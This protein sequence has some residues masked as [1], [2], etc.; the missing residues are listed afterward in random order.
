MNTSNSIVKRFRLRLAIAAAILLSISALPVSVGTL[1]AVL[2]VSPAFAHPTQAAD[3]EE[4]G[5]SHDGS[6]AQET[7]DEEAYL[8]AL[9]DVETEEVEPSELAAF[10]QD[11][12][13][14]VIELREHLKQARL[15][16]QMFYTLPRDEAAPWKQSYEETIEKGKLSRLKLA[17]AATKLFQVTPK[18][19]FD[20]MET[21]VRVN[22]M[23]FDLGLYEQCLELNDRLIQ[24]QPTDRIWFQRA[25]AFSMLNR[26]EEF[27]EFLKNSEEEQAGKAL[28]AMEEFQLDAAVNFKRLP[29]IAAKWERE[30]EF[31]KKETEAGDLPRV[32]I[33]TSK[34]TITVELFE[35]EAP[36]AV[37][38]FVN[39]V[40]DEFYDGKVFHRVINHFMAQGGGTNEFGEPAEVPY[41]IA[42]EHQ[43]ETARHHFRGSLC[44]AR[45]N[46]P[47]SAAAEFYITFAPGPGLDNNYTVFGRV[48]AGWDALDQLERTVART[49]DAE[50]KMTYAP[51]TGADPDKIINATVLRKREHEYDTEPYQTK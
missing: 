31:R 17:E 41:T 24:F 25:C 11:Y 39:L 47:N 50:G 1:I 12:D 14:I 15:A 19:S 9:P 28:E 51:V 13:D 30:L 35:N 36:I 18:P 29:E 8:A 46:Q 44:M 40:E 37:N 45:S 38:N 32:Q 49:G 34:G 16:S 20:L 3:Q 10:Q 33:K 4:H 42:D 23:Q 43:Q 48:I 5:H 21:V 27:V 22:Q 6:T 2:S 26:S 7:I